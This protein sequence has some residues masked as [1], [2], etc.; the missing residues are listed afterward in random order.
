MNESK[1]ACLGA[2]TV[3]VRTTEHMERCQA[4]GTE[5]QHQ[6]VNHP[7]WGFQAGCDRQE[8]DENP[9]KNPGNRVEESQI[10]YSHRHK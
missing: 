9:G 3:P 7:F 6:L 2:P 5:V 10:C 8:R 4:C 1:M